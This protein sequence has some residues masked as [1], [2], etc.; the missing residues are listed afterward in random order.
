M[1][2]ATKHF[3]MSDLNRGI[4]LYM[5]LSLGK[6]LMR[7]RHQAIKSEPWHTIFQQGILAD[8]TGTV[9]VIIQ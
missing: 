5:T 1:I 3:E 2:W 7:E 8:L 4:Y 9:Q 6:K